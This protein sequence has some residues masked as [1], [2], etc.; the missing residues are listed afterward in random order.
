MDDLQTQEP[1]EKPV[2]AKRTLSG[3]WLN[4]FLAILSGV[5]VGLTFPPFEWWPLAW[6][7][8]IPLLIALRR[9]SAVR[10]SGYLA[11]LFGVS[12]CATSLHWMVAIFGALCIGIF[13][14]ASL[15][16]LLFG[17]AYRTLADRSRE[18]VVLLLTPV[19]WLAVD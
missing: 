4:I 12:L 19:L 16:W 14:L 8:L 2:T 11:L 17:L 6:V 3:A 5:L 1:Q 13:V 9:T 10:F 15:P 7:A 18:W